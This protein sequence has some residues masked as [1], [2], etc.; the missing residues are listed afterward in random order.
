VDRSS[1]FW[2]IAK[3]SAAQFYRRA[4]NFRPQIGTAFKFGATA[5][6]A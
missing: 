5:R 3:E 4:G 1:I 6:A 2:T